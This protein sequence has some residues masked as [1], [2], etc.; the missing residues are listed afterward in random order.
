MHKIDYDGNKYVTK[1]GGANSVGALAVKLKEVKI[2]RYNLTRS[3]QK[4]HQE[5]IN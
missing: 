3:A 5:G 1:V 4:A 2:H